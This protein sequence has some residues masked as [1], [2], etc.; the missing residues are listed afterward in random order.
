MFSPLYTLSSANMW[1]TSDDSDVLHDSACPSTAAP[2]QAVTR[3]TH[4][5]IVKLKENRYDFFFT[6]AGILFN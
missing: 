1:L 2:S 3:N 5:W 6:L 4:D